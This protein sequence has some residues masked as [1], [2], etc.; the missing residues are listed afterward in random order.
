MNED[1]KYFIEDM[2]DFISS[3]KW[4]EFKDFMKDKGFSSE[5]VDQREDDLDNFINN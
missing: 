3:G 4:N 5:V 2:Y 1:L